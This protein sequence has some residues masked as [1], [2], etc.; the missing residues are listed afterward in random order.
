V[1]YLAWLPFD[2]S[3][4][5]IAAAMAGLYPG[6]VA[7]STFVLASAPAAAVL[8]R[9]ASTRSCESPHSSQ[10]APD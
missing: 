9:F 3:I 8:H 4:V 5:L 1:A 6:A 7:L 2:D 10:K